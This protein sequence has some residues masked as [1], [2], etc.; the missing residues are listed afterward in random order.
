MFEGTHDGDTIVQ[1][2]CFSA[3][4]DNDGVIGRED[5]SDLNSRGVFFL[6]FCA[7]HCVSITNTVFEHKTVHMS[8]AQIGSSNPSFGKALRAFQGST[9]S[10]SYRAP[11]LP[12]LI[13][14]A[15]APR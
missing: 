10:P 15:V 4:M 6:H 9:M 14:G 1:L 12:K 8:Y 11:L 13:Y 5:L 3:H 2:D 7:N